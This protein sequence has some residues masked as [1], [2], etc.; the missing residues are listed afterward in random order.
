[1]K[2]IGLI[3]G[4]SWESSAEYYR[5]INEA[6]KDKLG[7]L[8]SAKIV[9]YSVDFEEI[10][11]LCHEENWNKVTKILIDAA[12]RLERAGANCILI[13]ANTLHRDADEIQR[14]VRIPIIH[15]VDVVA[16]RIKEKG[17]R[18]V[19]LLGTKFVM[20]GDFYRKRLIE[21]H[22][23]NVIIPSKKERQIVHDVI[24]NELYL[25]KIKQSSKKQLKKIIQNLVAR[26]AKGIILGCT[27]IP[28]LVKQR[29]VKV[30]LFDTTTIHAISAVEYALK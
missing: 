3:G 1:M 16:K 12:K 7:E 27:E 26:G 9:M 23:I 5:I 22:D 29:D 21:K 25:G 15:I 4:V 19:G 6:V 18:K 10:A 28:L 2:T 13:C 30:L 11:R 14:S 24:Y 8:H 20:E 17:L